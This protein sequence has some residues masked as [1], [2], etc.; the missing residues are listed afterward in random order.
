MLGWTFDRLNKYWRIKAQHEQWDYLGKELY[1]VMQANHDNRDAFVDELLARA[2]RINSTAGKQGT[3]PGKIYLIQKAIVS[4]QALSQ[5]PYPNED[6]FQTRLEQYP[7]PLAGNRMNAGRAA[8]A[9]W[10]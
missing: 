4:L 6:D 2:A 3:M 10:R 9:K 8:A 7:D 5:Q 1:R